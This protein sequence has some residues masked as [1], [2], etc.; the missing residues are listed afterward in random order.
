MAATWLRRVRGQALDRTR[1]IF[2]SGFFG[3]LLGVGYGVVWKPEINKFVG[4]RGGWFLLLVPWIGGVIAICIAAYSRRPFLERQAPQAKRR[5]SGGI[6]WFNVLYL[7]LF[8]A[9]AFEWEE[10]RLG[11]ATLIPPLLITVSWLGV[12]SWLSLKK[13]PYFQRSLT[14]SGVL[15]AV[16]TIAYSSIVALLITIA[17]F[18]IRFLLKDSPE[19][20]LSE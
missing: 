15:A 10:Y 14:I 5:P 6:K 13:R 8:I 11:R 7:A 12:L 20:S 17:L 16:F 4:L 18:L 3:I 1:K 2:L 9:A 19:A